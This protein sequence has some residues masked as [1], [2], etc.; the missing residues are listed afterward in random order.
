MSS[1][2]STSAMST[3]SSRTPSSKSC[4]ISPRTTLTVF[5]SNQP[6]RATRATPSSRETLTASVGP[7]MVGTALMGEDLTTTGPVASIVGSRTLLST[8]V[9]RPTKLVEAIS[10]PGLGDEQGRRA[11]VVLELGA[12]VGDVHPQQLR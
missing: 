8:V 11:G 6:P 5:A 7:G 3:R 12:D 10:D 2:N 4:S 9:L 1:R